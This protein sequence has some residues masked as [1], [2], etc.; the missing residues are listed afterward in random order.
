MLTSQTSD[1]QDSEVAVRRFFLTDE[2]LWRAIAKN[3]NELSNLLGQEVEPGENGTDKDLVRR[4]RLIEF[5]K[6]QREYRG[7]TAEIR[8]RYS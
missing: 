2:Q 7:Y 6:L 5:N 4:A 8:R 3:T 1:D